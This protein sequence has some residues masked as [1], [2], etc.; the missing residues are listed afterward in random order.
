M[1][2]LSSR[3]PW[4]NKLIPGKINT[5]LIILLVWLWYHPPA[6]VTQQHRVVPSIDI[7]LLDGR[8][9]QLSSLRGQVVLV[10]FWAT[11][12]PWCR[13]EMPDIAR[14]YRDWHTHG[15]TVLALSLDDNP[16]LAEQ[17]MQQHDYHWPTGI[18]DTNSQLAFGG[19]GQIPASFIIDQQGVL[20]YSIKGQIYYG[21]LISLVQPLLTR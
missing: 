15:I 7:H 2:T 16:Q 11:W 13:K 12:C 6:W 17:Y 1:F 5:L 21:R 14:F 18:A 3:H 8:M 9:I 4:L 19:V 10:N 20:R